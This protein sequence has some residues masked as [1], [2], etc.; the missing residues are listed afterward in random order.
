MKTLLSCLL[1]TTLACSSGTTSP[2]ESPSDGRFPQAD[3]SRF[4]QAPA[5][6]VETLPADVMVAPDLGGDQPPLPEYCSDNGLQC[7]A[8]QSDSDGAV[9]PCG[10]CPGANWCTPVGDCQSFP[11]CGPGGLISDSLLTVSAGEATAFSPQPGDAFAGLVSVRTANPEACPWCHRAVLIRRPTGA[12]TEVLCQDL[13]PVAACGKG[14]GGTVVLD[15]PAG[16]EAGQVVTLT[17]APPGMHC[18]DNWS[19]ELAGTTFD[20]TQ[21]TLP[22]PEAG[23]ACPPGCDGFQCGFVGQSCG[24]KVS[25]GHCPPD[26]VCVDHQCSLAPPCALDQLAITDVLLDGFKQD[27]VANPGEEVP[28]LFSWTLSG[29]EAEDD[30]P[31]QLVV[32]I[33]PQAGFCV[34]VGYV[35]SCP[36]MSAG[37]A[38]GSL[39]APYEAG[40]YA[41]EVVA[42]A[43]PD[44]AR[45]LGEFAQAWPRQ[46]LGT[47]V[48]D[49]QCSPLDCPSLGAECGPRNDGCGGTIWCGDCPPGRFCQA[50][51]CAAEPAC[52][53]DAFSPLAL[54]V[55]GQGSQAVVGRKRLVA[56]AL[57]L[58]GATGSSCPTCP[59]LAAI[60]VGDDVVLCRELDEIPQC[61]EYF[62]TRIGGLF[63]PPQMPGT[64]PVRA[65]LLMEDDCQVAQETFLDYPAV[66][67]GTL[68]V[69]GTCTPFDCAALSKDCGDWGDG[70]GGFLHCGQCLADE[71]CSLAGACENPCTH[72]IFEVLG[73]SINGSGTVASSPPD[74]SVQVSLGYQVGNRED[75]PL[76]PIQL[77]FGIDNTPQECVPAGTP[78]A[79]PA[80]VG[81]DVV[82]HLQAPGSAGAYSLYALPSTALDCDSAKAEYVA[83]PNRK[84]LGTLHVTDGCVPKSCLAMG[85]KCGQWEDGCNTTLSCGSCQATQLCDAMGSC[86]CSSADPFEP[87]NSADLAYDFGDKNDNDGSSHVTVM[88]AVNQESDWFRMGATDKQWAYMEPFVQ[89]TPGAPSG[90]KAVVVFQCLEGTYP[91]SYNELITAGCVQKKN[92]SYPGL[93]GV[94]SA[95]ECTPVNGVITL[96]F[97]PHCQLVDDSGELYVSVSNSGPCSAYELDLHL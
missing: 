13:G 4:D 23:P 85:K 54:D 78:E 39:V 88:A 94:G 6:R 1:V 66:T 14:S 10:N 44:C 48:V 84:K 16:A 19:E 26:H 76:C 86:Y 90:F 92:V 83:N 12:S 21:V 41:L 62:A 96:Q 81:G 73:I 89:V 68:T 53:Q 33:G 77:V 38:N 43:A 70:C 34:E 35:E 60:M 11:T 51:Q 3:I 74:K 47:V 31:R 95:F 46:T 58:E 87:N 72:G 20:T 80:T 93:G 29:A 40:N 63:S 49:G 9:W 91:T 8:W 61:P 45:A 59:R 71:V 42:I 50:G 56:M 69:T 17:P 55:Q 82:T 5:D 79:C 57:T 27:A 67:V 24:L 15:F 32:G 37:L 36:A 97:G 25:C 2:P 28:V 52:A 22:G 65:A 30:L 7:G 18:A 64:Y 75:C